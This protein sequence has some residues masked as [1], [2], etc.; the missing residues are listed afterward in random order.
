MLKNDPQIA[1]ADSTR[2]FHVDTARFSLMVNCWTSALP[3]LVRSVL[4][5]PPG[6]WS[7]SS[8]SSSSASPA[9]DSSLLE[10][11]PARAA[12]VVG[13]SSTSKASTIMACMRFFV[14]VVEPLR[15][16]RKCD[17]RQRPVI[18][19]RVQTAR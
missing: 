15:T 14:V 16:S 1:K 7:S 5:L 3:F 4:L 18:Y 6:P 10:T 11:L 17:D 19:G 8:S 13:A 12:R 9:W 2:N